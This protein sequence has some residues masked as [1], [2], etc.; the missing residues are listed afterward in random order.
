MKASHKLN[1]RS[2]AA[3]V[4][5]GVIA[6][7]SATAFL[8]GRAGAQG[9]NYTGVTDCDSGTGHDRPGYGSGVRNQYTDSDTGPNA[10][11]RCHGR[12]PNSGSPSG[13]EYHG[14]PRTGCTDQDRGQYAD[15]GGYGRTCRGGEINPNALGR[16]SGCTDSDSGPNADPAGDGRCTPR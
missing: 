1:R 15:A 7:G 11:P 8:A 14:R 3:S 12:A 9:R 16:P 4:L 5:G 2:F 13:T 10:D 6:G